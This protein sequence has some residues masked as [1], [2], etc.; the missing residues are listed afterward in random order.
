MSR[1]AIQKWT[2]SPDEEASFRSTDSTFEWLCNLPADLLR[3][4]GGK[5]VA[6][7]DCRVVAAADSLDGLLD[8]LGDAD[9]KTLIIDRIERPVWVIYR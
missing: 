9:P 2:P 4:Y 1:P 8:Q 6:A 7:K 3:Q 5:W